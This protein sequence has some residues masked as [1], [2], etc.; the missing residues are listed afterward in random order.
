MAHAMIH[1][2]GLIKEAMLNGKCRVCKEHDMDIPG[3]SICSE[4]VQGE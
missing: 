4:C 2:F 3:S 1:E